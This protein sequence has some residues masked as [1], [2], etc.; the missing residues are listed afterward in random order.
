[1]I[2]TV[3]TMRMVQA[4]VDQITNMVAMWNGLMSAAGAMDMTRLMPFTRLAG[5][6]DVG[7]AVA[8]LN[9]VFVY[10]VTMHVMQVPIMQVINV[11]AVLDGGM[12]AARPML[13]R[14]IFMFWICA[15]AHLLTPFV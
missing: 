6:T 8:D 13:V 12:S 15:I 4:A 3:V 9:E 1:M 11:I 14:M 10:M 7:I 5:R 2:I